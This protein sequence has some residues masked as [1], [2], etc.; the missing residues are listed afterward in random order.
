MITVPDLN[1]GR[2]ECPLPECKRRFHTLA[3]KKQHIKLKHGK[4]VRS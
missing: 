3:E 1:A 2:Y 4:K